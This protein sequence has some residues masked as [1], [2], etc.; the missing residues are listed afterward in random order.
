MDPLEKQLDPRSPFTFR[1][2]SVPEFIRNTIVNCDLP[3]GGVGVVSWPPLPDLD[4]PME[5][6]KTAKI[7]N[8][9]NQVPQLTQGTTLESDKN[10]IKHHKQGLSQQVTTRRQ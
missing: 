7:R 4:P 2:W 5:V 6:R 9:Y 10:T 1:D 3:R 8:R